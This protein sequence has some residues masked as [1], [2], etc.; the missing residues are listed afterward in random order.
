MISPRPEKKDPLV[1]LL[2]IFISFGLAFLVALGAG[3][4]W[5]AIWPSL[6]FWPIVYLSW[7]AIALMNRSAS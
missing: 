6:P 1:L 5:T 2:A 4:A 7:I 3:W